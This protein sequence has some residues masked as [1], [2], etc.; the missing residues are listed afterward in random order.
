MATAYNPGISTNGLVTCIDAANL[1]SYNPNL[2][3][4]L[5]AFGYPIGGTVELDVAPDSSTVL[6]RHNL[7][8]QV[9]PFMNARA[10]RTLTPGV[11][12]I[13]VWARATTS[14][15]A[16]FAFVGETT[17]EIT[18]TTINVTPTWTRFTFT[19]TLAAQQTA[20][21]LQI[22]FGTQG[23]DKIISI[24]G[25]ELVRGS[26]STPNYINSNDRGITWYD[27]INR[28]NAITVYGLPAYNSAGHITL[29]NDQITQYAMQNSYAIPTAAVTFS[30]WFRSNF[31]Q[32]NQTPFTY[33]VGGDNTFLLFT[34][35]T[36]E[37]APFDINNAYPITVTN[38]QNRWC[39]FTWTRVSATGVSVYYMDGVQVGTRTY[40]PGTSPVS[41][42]Y[43]IIGQESDLA[44]GGFD[45][46]Q[47]L[48]GD[49]A[50]LDIYNRAIT[51][52]EVQQNFAAIRGRFGI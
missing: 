28:S 4:T 11:Y 38:M 32:P 14:F 10:D 8:G 31:A 15:S 5:G 48:D 29:G 19:F 34:N 6:C 23:N 36:T 22:F 2:M 12:T 39:N 3:T 43:L 13:S 41:G 21:R 45:A 16:A 47:N 7:T 44:G 26:T 24:W 50:R 49:F 20:S 46:A 40:L 37:I 30:C 9:S 17:G 18:T 33:S 25:L 35:S 52:A 51:A 42:G 27:S 1:K